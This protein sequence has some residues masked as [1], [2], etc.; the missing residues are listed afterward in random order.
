MQVAAILFAGFCSLAL[1]GCVYATGGVETFNLQP[2]PGGDAVLETR[3]ASVSFALSPTEIAY[4]RDT[5]RVVFKRRDGER[6][7]RF[8]SMDPND[9][10][11]LC[12]RAGGDYA[13]LV[14]QRRI[15]ESAISQAADDAAI[16]RSPS[17]TAVCRDAA[18]WTRT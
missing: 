4:A 16:L 10:Y 13:L 8:V 18:N 12:L 1:S 11:A 6:T 15:Y 5:A 2:G 7:T 3:S 14:F 17:D 9:G